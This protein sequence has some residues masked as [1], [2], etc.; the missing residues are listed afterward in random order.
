MTKST[1]IIAAVI[2]VLFAAVA[3]IIQL[4]S[5]HMHNDPEELHNFVS[6]AVLF[7]QRIEATGLLENIPVLTESIAKE[8]TDNSSE[9]QNLIQQGI[10]SAKGYKDQFTWL[11]PTSQ[12]LTLYESLVREGSLIQK[13]YSKLYSA[14]TVKQAGNEVLCSQYLGETTTAYNELVSLRDQNTTTLNNLLM[15]FE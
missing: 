9:T 11:T 4:V 5:S 6:G 10:L 12:T 3:G 15:Q 7:H 13:C 8:T 14:W 1:I 2:I